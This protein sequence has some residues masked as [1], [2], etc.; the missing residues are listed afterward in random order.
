[1]AKKMKYNVLKAE[2]AEAGRDSFGEK[3]F[4][5]S[6][7]VIGKANSLEHAKEKFGGYPVLEEVL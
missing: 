4:T 6:F 2:Y 1:M 5:V 3:Q 7:R